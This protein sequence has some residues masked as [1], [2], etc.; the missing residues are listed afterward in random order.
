MAHR[1][2]HQA[3][4]HLLVKGLDVVQDH[5][6]LGR[7][8]AV[9][10]SPH[11]RAETK[12]SLLKF[13][14][15]QREVPHNTHTTHIIIIARLLYDKQGKRSPRLTKKESQERKFHRFL[16]QHMCISTTKP[17]LQYRQ[18]SS[19]TPSSPSPKMTT[20]PTTT[21]RMALGGHGDSMCEMGDVT[22]NASLG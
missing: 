7:V 22:V 5:V 9:L 6:H 2:A 8:V 20:S 13:H 17:H 19:K 4:P 14:A 1:R 12:L 3:A 15:H 18:Y 16:S 11:G 10:S 21:F